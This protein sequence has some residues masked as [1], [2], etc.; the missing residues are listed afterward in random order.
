MDK[1]SRWSD[2]WV[3]PTPPGDKH[4]QLGPKSYS[5]FLPKAI[6]ARTVKNALS[7]LDRFVEEYPLH[8]KYADE[9]KAYLNEHYGQL[10]NT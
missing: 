5:L 6:T 3:Y 4:I 9:C 1:I 8:R 2:L 7:G 10:L